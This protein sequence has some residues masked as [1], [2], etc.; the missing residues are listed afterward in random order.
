MP[1]PN[2]QDDRTGNDNLNPSAQNY[3]GTFNGLEA[4]KQAANNDRKTN[5]TNNQSIDERENNPNLGGIS[6]IPTTYSGAATKIVGKMTGKKK[7]AL[8]GVVVFVL[9]MLGI[10]S[11]LFTPGLG[12]IQMKEMLTG[13]LNDQLAAMDIRSSHVF[14]AKLSTMSSGICTGVQIKCK[15]SSM[16]QKQV[17][18]FKNA[19]FTIEDENVKSGVFG[20]VFVSTMTAPDGTVINNPADLTKARNSS[21]EVRSAMNRVFSPLYY[22]LSDKVA[23]K[24]F[25]ENK[26]NK[27]KKI[28]GETEEERRQSITDAT[29]GEKAQGGILKDS[30]GNYI[31]DSDGTR[32][33]ESDE[34]DRYTQLKEESDAKN[35]ALNEKEKVGGKAVSSVLSVAGGAVKGLSVL[36][37]ADSACTVYNTARAVSAAA[38]VARSMQLVQF[39]MVINTTADSIKAGDATPE[40]V[41]TVGKMLSNTDSRQTITSETSGETVDNPFYGKSA[42]DSPGYKTVAY[43]ESPTLT[44]Q[45]QQYMVGGG[46]SGSLSSVIS[47]IEKDLG[48]G[49]PQAL[50][51]TCGIVQS[52]WVR[53]IGLIGGIFLAIGSFGVGT[54]ISIAGSVAVSFALPFLESALADIVAG[55]VVSGDTQGVE[56]GDATMAGTAASLGGIAQRRGM[57][58]MSSSGLEQYLASTSESTGDAIA[59]EKYE[60][61]KTPFDIN[62]QYSFVGSFAR[63]LYPISLT[64]KSSVSGA[65]S[66]VG[67]ILSQGFGSLI[68]PASAAQTFN[69]DRFTKCNDPGYKELGIDADVFCNVRY[70]FTDNELSMETEAVVDYMYDNG[71]IGPS[72]LA[73]GEYKT[74][75]DHCVNRED[76]WGETSEENG[77]IGSE[78]LDK[79][80]VIEEGGIT[81]TNLSYFRIYTM[82]KTINDAMDDEVEEEVGSEL[83]G[84]PDGAI[85]SDRGWTLAD[86][87]DYSK[88]PC[89]SRTEDMGIYTSPVNGITVRL[90]KIS[91]NT[92][93]LRNGGNQVASV[94]SANVMNMFEAARAAGVELGI[95]DGMRLTFSGGYTSMHTYGVA[96]DIGTPRSGQTIC[97]GGNSQTG[98]GSAENAERACRSRG[99]IHYAAYQWLQQNAAQYGFYNYLV[100]PWHWSSSG[101]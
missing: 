49:N 14:K 64:A 35:A 13:N 2:L 77:S 68:K 32:V 95:S 29:A 94:V 30:K 21:Q 22:S 51:S 52:P 101:R 8:A 73:L 3:E 16:T 78:C 76:G 9:G 15:F 59:L 44:P 93:E 20:R 89:D 97:Y 92:P 80:G 45:S 65:I 55:T 75:L 90:C 19:G 46:L 62:S 23:N 60:A 36:G 57:T 31:V 98:Y 6:S 28:T 82:D 91:F 17:D 96:I 38:K 88:Y 40:E 79:S 41:E 25:S 85:D 66:S 47:G 58:P 53:G 10:G 24:F 27:Q 81:K 34:G 84:K 74:F 1:A 42:Y 56:A 63:S 5:E 71:F 39:A 37:A 70:G 69:A 12:V 54:A 7:G 83:V 11:T 26:T 61:S 100:E 67:S 18:R 72:G 99:G 4:E 50:R 48:G 33:Y 43:N 87:V 86:G